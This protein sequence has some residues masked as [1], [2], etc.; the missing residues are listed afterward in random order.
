MTS[1]RNRVAAV[2]A[3]AAV[4]AVAGPAAA[5]SMFDGIPGLSHYGDADGWQVRK[6]DSDDVWYGRACVLYRELTAGPNPVQAVYRFEPAED[7]VSL[8]FRIP[9][10]ESV[11]DRDEVDWGHLE[12]AEFQYAVDETEIHDLG[13][14]IGFEYIDPNTVYA[15]LRLDGDAAAVDRIAAAE[16]V[17][18]AVKGRQGLLFPT[19][20]ATRAVSLARRCL[21]SF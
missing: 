4:L 10:A 20:R 15:E 11:P 18:V 21:R 9:R 14:T 19:G 2:A 17:A 3:L 5:Q 16:Q 6:L 1:N 13:G 7:E 8:V 12:P